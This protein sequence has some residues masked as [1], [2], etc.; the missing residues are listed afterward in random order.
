M[1][2]KKFCIKK[3]A[4]KTEIHGAYHLIFCMGRLKMVCDDLKRRP[5]G[6]KNSEFEQTRV[7]K[8]KLWNTRGFP[9]H[10][11]KTN[12]DITSCSLFSNHLFSKGDRCI[13]VL[14]HIFRFLQYEVKNK[15]HSVTIFRV[16]SVQFALQTVRSQTRTKI[17]RASHEFS[18]LFYESL[19]QTTYQDLD[20]TLGGSGS[21]DQNVWH[22]NKALS[23]KQGEQNANWQSSNSVQQNI[24]TKETFLWSVI[25]PLLKI[26]FVWYSWQEKKDLIEHKNF[27]VT[28]CIHFNIIWSISL[29]PS[30]PAGRDSV[31]QRSLCD[32]LSPCVQ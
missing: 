3:S 25:H 32:L 18:V 2:L 19:A 11:E 23:V 15:I 22:G 26:S 29:F 30:F 27:E 14:K 21:I 9:W 28:I 12:Y 20:L 24:H 16:T 13:M 7:S 10:S 17:S 1:I 6:L 4:K 8:V 5:V 31:I